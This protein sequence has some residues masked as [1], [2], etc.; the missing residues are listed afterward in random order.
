[1]SS[2]TPGVVSDTEPAR[3]PSVGTIVR[4]A[5]V[6]LTL[7]AIVVACV[8][9]T[10]TLTPIPFESPS[11]A[12]S[13]EVV[14]ASD[15][16]AP[17]VRRAR[18]SRSRRRA[19]PRPEEPASRPP[20]QVVVKDL[21]TAFDLEIDGER[22]LNRR[23]EVTPGQHHLVL[24]FRGVFFAQLTVDV[25]EGETKEVSMGAFGG[26][27]G[28]CVRRWHSADLTPESGRTACRASLTEC[29]HGLA[30]LAGH[31]GTDGMWSPVLFHEQC[32]GDA[33]EGVSHGTADTTATA[34]ALMT[35]FGF[36]ETHQSGQYKANVKAGLKALRARQDANGWFDANRRR[37]EHAIATLAMVEAYVL[38]GSRLWKRSALRGV[39][40]VVAQAT[41]SSIEET[42][43]EALVLG[44]WMTDMPDD[45]AEA[46]A[47]TLRRLKS[48]GAPVDH[49]AREQALLLAGRAL[50]QESPEEDEALT[51]AADGLLE[52]ADAWAEDPGRADPQTVLFTLIACYR[53]GGKRWK[54]WEPVIS[55]LVLSRQRDNGS[56]DPQ[57]GTEY[58]RVGTTALNVLAAETYYRYRCVFGRR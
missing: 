9:A 14:E 49:P 6:L 33:C 12:E 16:D 54:A 32:V 50:L 53:I 28:P 20:T 42:A 3:R 10:S 47:E 45:F 11:E 40:I 35:F 58:G 55:K 7:F 27:V 39:E 46:R 57:P 5:L 30:W 29:D 43:W 17:P 36:G 41:S 22:R 15:W 18:R 25:P 31:Q 21:T 8:V 34:L 19:E 38:T 48:F 44:S 13:P 52:L 26:R 23:T 2:A 24:K 51:A 4:R 56:W 1:M 37:R